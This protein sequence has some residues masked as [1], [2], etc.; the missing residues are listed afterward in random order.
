MRRFLRSSS[1]ALVLA[2]A[3]SGAAQAGPIRERASPVRVSLFETFQ[4][5]LRSLAPHP[6]GLTV[7]WEEE[8]SI[9][10]PNG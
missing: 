8:G 2:L 1:V 5:W 6:G 10:D 9:M 7:L 3:L 4:V